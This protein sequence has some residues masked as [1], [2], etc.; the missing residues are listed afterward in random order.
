MDE[1]MEGPLRWDAAR[2]VK[3][4]AAQ[5]VSLDE[6]VLGHKAVLRAACDLDWQG[7]GGSCGRSTQ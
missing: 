5:Q 7:G 2:Y 6:A 3:G 1:L 4:P